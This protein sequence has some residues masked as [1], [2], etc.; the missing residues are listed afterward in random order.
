MEMLWK[1]SDDIVY[2]HY[3]FYFD[4][5]VVSFSQQGCITAYLTVRICGNLRH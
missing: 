1:D 2:T 3:R 4:I 5:N